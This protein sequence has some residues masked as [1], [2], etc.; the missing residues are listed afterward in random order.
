MINNFIKMSTHPSSFKCRYCEFNNHSKAQVLI[1]ERLKH[2]MGYSNTVTS[3]G[4]WQEIY[5]L[6]QTS[7]QMNEI[8]QQIT[9][10]QDTVHCN[11]CGDDLNIMD[12][13]VASHLRSHLRAKLRK[14]L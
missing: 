1:H 8:M 3:L 4:K 6:A 11:I 7:H 5:H 10:S 12:D 13:S 2:T 14:Y 9:V